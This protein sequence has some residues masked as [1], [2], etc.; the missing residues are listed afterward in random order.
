M[1]PWA[2]VAGGVALVALLVA[3]LAYGWGRDTGSSPDSPAEAGPSALSPAPTVT[4]EGV[5]SEVAPTNPSTPD[6]SPRRQLP[7]KVLAISVDGLSAAAIKEEGPAKLPTLHRLLEEGAATLNARS[8]AERSVTLPNHVGM[9]TG[10]RIDAAHGG[11]G[12]TWNSDRAHDT[13]QRAAGSEV[14]STRMRPRPNGNEGVGP[15]L[16]IWVSTDQLAW[17]EETRI[18]RPRD[19]RKIWPI[20]K[21]QKDDYFTRLCGTVEPIGLRYVEICPR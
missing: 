2:R 4:E 12:V 6:A 8:A 1:A 14:A 9:V 15:R 10:R 18:L 21:Y 20:S 17:T 13:V 5:P 7:A 3:T 19:T 11:H 16:R